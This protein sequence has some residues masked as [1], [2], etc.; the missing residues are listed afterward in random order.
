M[1]EFD[2]IN[3]YF[4][5]QSSS[6]NGVIQSV[7]DDAAILALPENTQLVTSIDTLISGVH[8]PVDTS[9]QDIGIKSLAV[10]LS[11]LAAMGATPAWF[12]LALSLPKKDTQWLQGFSA[13]LKEIAT[14]YNCDLVGGDTTRNTHGSVSIS[15]QVMGW[16]ENGTA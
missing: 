7:G 13:G 3:H 11:D 4:N 8:F 1:S 10:N 5:W 16:L 15:I 9:P 12:T 2:L 6:N 14:Q